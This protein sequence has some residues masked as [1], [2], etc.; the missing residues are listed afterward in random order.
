M[1]KL[2]VKSS[3]S[4]RTCSLFFGA[5][6]LVG[7][8]SPKEAQAQY[9]Y[10]CSNPIYSGSYSSCST[11]NTANQNSTVATS[12]SIIRS[13]TTQISSL[14]AQRVSSAVSGDASSF[15]V[16]SNGYV[17]TGVAAGDHDQKFGL[18]AAGAYAGLEDEN[19]S[20]EF[21]GHSVVGTVGADY[22]V[23]SDVVL[24]I[25]LGYEDIDVDTAYNGFGGI[26]GNISADGFGIA[27]YIGVTLS[28]NITADAKVGYA[29]MEYDTLR[30]DP[31]TGNRITGSTDADRYFVDAGIKGRYT[32]Q[33]NWGADVRGSV[34]Y[35]HEEKDAF[36]ENEAG[37]AT[38]AV[39]ED[40]TE[41]G[42]FLL[43]TR[44]GY[45]MQ[46]IRPYGL[47]GLEY[48]FVKDDVPVAA[49]Q[50]QASDSRFGAK[51]GAGV[52]FN[53][54]PNVTGGVEAYTVEFRDDFDQYVVS[55]GL[56]VKF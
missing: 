39:D 48:D 11:N 6:L 9:S 22:R 55:G 45:A 17:G 36:T 32:L 25:A 42:Q 12:N 21:D 40:T 33:G 5:A 23:T 47:V 37:G 4:F 34:F 54:A 2:N 26:D 46:G 3:V 53:F 27:P 51:L 24:G 18:W 14:I 20:T 29:D 13:T 19:R 52:D 56:R 49:G 28:D 43:D 8:S 38:I 10:S 1:S 31:N 16:S 15:Q 41:L 44:V 7:I 50:V 35:A 30:F